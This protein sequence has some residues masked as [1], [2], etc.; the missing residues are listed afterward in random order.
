MSCHLQ[1]RAVQAYLLAAI[2]FTMPFLPA[3]L[4]KDSPAVSQLSVGME[5][6]D[7]HKADS[8]QVH[9]LVLRYHDTHWSA[10][11]NVGLACSSANACHCIKAYLLL[12][13]KTF[14]GLEGTI[15][16]L[17]SRSRKLFQ[18]E[19]D[20]FMDDYDDSG[21]P[22]PQGCSSAYDMS[23]ECQQA[24]Q[25]LRHREIGKHSPQNRSILPCQLL[26]RTGS[27]PEAL[28]VISPV[29]CFYLAFYNA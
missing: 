10:T 27:F 8:P 14:K 23:Q 2:A 19:Y 28:N 22:V 20:N 17:E 18:M 7:M 15:T 29:V 4:A 9:P 25:A 24:Q 5:V 6:P 16:E 3:A 21:P 11:E 1:S 26:I 13:Q 12:A